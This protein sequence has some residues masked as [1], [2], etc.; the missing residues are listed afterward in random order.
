LQY[1]AAI[2]APDTGE[3]SVE[4]WNLTSSLKEEED[5]LLQLNK[6]L[7]QHIV[8]YVGVSVGEAGVRICVCVHTGC[9]FIEVSV[10]LTLCISA[11]Q[12]C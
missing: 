11:Y 6:Q 12:R 7:L 1:A 8:V 10:N 5:L 4:L 3:V 2:D 9:L